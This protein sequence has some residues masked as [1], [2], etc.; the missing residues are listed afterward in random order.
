M[1]FTPKKYLDKR[2]A[3]IYN[4]NKSWTLAFQKVRGVNFLHRGRKAMKFDIAIID[5]EPR[6][7][8][9]LRY[10][11]EKYFAGSRDTCEIKTYTSAEAFCE[12]YHADTDIV[13]FDID[14]PGMNGMEAARFIRE[15]DNKVVIVFV[16]KM[17]QF[18]IEGYT[19]QAFDFIVKPINEGSFVIKF[20]RILNMVR[21]VSDEA[22]VTLN[23]VGGKKRVFVREIIY[24]EVRN[25]YLTYHMS[26]GEYVV[27]GTMGEAE[28]LLSGYHFGRCNA[29]YLVNMKHISDFRGDW[30]TAGGDKLKISQSKKQEFL[31]EFAKY[32]GGGSC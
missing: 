29:C 24:V 21:K 16:T 3:A 10:M 15:R 1:N 32:L 28:K 20:D 13:F 14:M 5:D 31:G 22:M 19:V 7:R 27:R 23:V 11:L 4:N 2:R 30:I 25:H 18:A 17:M 9:H 8:E 26:D 6:E 12:G